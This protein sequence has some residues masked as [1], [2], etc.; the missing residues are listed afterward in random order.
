MPTF[1]TN[2][3]LDFL[4]SNSFEIDTSVQKVMENLKEFH[5]IRKSKTWK[6]RT[7][8]WVGRDTDGPPMYLPPIKN[9]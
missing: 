2:I 3:E 1:I 4:L 5:K 6:T 9:W 8:F 7:R